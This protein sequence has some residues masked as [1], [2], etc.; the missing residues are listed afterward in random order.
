MFI[1][2]LK[3][4]RNCKILPY[5]TITPSTSYF[6]STCLESVGRHFNIAHQPTTPYRLLSHSTHHKMKFPG[7]C[8]CHAIKYEI[9]LESK[10]DAR[11]SI[12][13]CKNCK[14]RR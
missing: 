11:T 9:D 2:Q 12:C 1:S 8:Y 14:V 4:L 5:K 6:T 3:S 13:H 10:D 7:S